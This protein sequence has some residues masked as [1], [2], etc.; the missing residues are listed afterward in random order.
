MND[1]D[2]IEM[3]VN[4][5]ASKLA[6]CGLSIPAIFFLELH[7]PLASVIHTAILAC[8]PIC[9][10]IFGHRQ[11]GLLREVFA[12]RERVE[13]LIVKLEELAAKKRS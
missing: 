1:S 6:V 13:Q 4:Q 9:S 11:V 12:S 5:L 10:P 7:K 3:A 2:N 8:E